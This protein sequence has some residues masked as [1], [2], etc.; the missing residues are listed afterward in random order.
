M[1]MQI[2]AIKDVKCGFSQPF[3]MVNDNVAL[4]GFIGSVQSPTP[5]LANSF[6]EDKQL[7]KLGELDDQTGEYKE[8]VRY[9]ASASNYVLHNTPIEEI[10]E[11]KE[12]GT[13]NQ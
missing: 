7:W 11:E 1:K 13:S 9:M 4:R 8:D 6:P 12:N 3:V 10:N 5:N 2:Y